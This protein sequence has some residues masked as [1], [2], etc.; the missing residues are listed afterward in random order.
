[1]TM[2]HTLMVLPGKKISKMTII[3]IISLGIKKCMTYVHTSTCVKSEVFYGESPVPTGK[4]RGG[5]IHSTVIF[6]G[7]A[8]KKLQHHAE[9]KPHTNTILAIT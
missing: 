4:G 9:S 3:S 5:W 1:M 2:Q 7:N 8:G 6:H